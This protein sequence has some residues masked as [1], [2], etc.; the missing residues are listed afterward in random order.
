MHTRQMS[1]I[2]EVARDNGYKVRGTLCQ[3][4]EDLALKKRQ[5]PCLFIERRGNHYGHLHVISTGIHK[6][7]LVRLMNSTTCMKEWYFQCPG[8]YSDEELD[9]KILDQIIGNIP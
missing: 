7:L 3:P 6:W 8:Y 4:F 2:I 5:V 9:A 1:R